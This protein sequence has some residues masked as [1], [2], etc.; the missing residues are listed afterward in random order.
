MESFVDGSEAIV[1]P[2][3]ESIGLAIDDE[4]RKFEEFGKIVLNERGLLLEPIV[5]FVEDSDYLG[6]CEVDPGE[7]ARTWKVFVL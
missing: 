7:V 4:L 1:G 6:S 2:F 3:M 5:H